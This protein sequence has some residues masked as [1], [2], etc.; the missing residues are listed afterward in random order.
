MDETD[1]QVVGWSEAGEPAAFV[2]LV[3]RHGPAVHAYLARRT[4]RQDADD[5]LG[6][7]WLQAFKGRASYDRRCPDARPWLYG[8]AR[9]VLRAHWRYVSRPMVHTVEPDSSDAWSDVDVRLDAAAQGETLRQVLT[10]LSED[11]REVLFLVV[12]EELTPAEVSLVLGIPQGTARSRLHR[13]LSA[14]RSEA[15]FNSSVLIRLYPKEA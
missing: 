2:E 15:A 13:A 3:W 9:N 1:E 8:I 4:G 6:E 10:A 11:E 12:W 7:V 5:L 14:F